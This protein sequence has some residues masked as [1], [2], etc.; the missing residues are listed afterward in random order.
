MPAA[1][2]F[3]FDFSSPYGYFASERI[4]ELAARYGRTVEWHP[5]LLGAVFKV[6]G[7]A[8]LPE[9]PLKGEY[10]LRDIP[11]TARHLGI[12]F[13]PPAVFP[14]ATLNPARGFYWLR[15]RDAKLA[16]AFAQVCYRAYFAEGI[17]ISDPERLAVFAD[18]L[19]LD[20]DA[21]AAGL[22][23]AAVKEQLRQANERAIA[24]GV[25]GSPFIIVDGEPFWG[26]DR[27]AQVE[28]WLQMGGF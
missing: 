23:D 20:R 4:D 6:T 9:L 27:L 1:I 2:D 18:S 15:Q 28:K 24:R 12:P 14:I 19:G 8:P 5:I 21:F 3:Y 7:S 17:D 22:G 25:F 13:R 26:S 10:A 16:R 11:R